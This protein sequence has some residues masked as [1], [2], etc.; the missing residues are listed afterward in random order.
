MRDETVNRQRTLFWEHETH[1]AIRKGD[2]K[3]VSLNGA[4]SEAWE[5]YDMSRVRTETVNV[6]KQYPGRV[7]ELKEEWMSWASQANVLPWPKERKSK[8]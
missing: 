4:D 6:A 7:M 5:L 3:L 2:W 8:K 1:S